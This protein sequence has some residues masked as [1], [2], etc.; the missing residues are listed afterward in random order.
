MVRCAALNGGGDDLARQRVRVVLELLLDL[1]DLDGGFVPH[2]VFYA[3]EDVS[4]R[5]F[6][7]QTR[8]FSSISIWLRLRLATSSCCAWML[9]AFLAS[10]SSFFS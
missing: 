4:F 1:L 9:A 3:L 2:V 6:L 7:R 5:F 10:S 8:D